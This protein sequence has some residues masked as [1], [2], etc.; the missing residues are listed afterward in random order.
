MAPELPRILCP[1]HSQGAYSFHVYVHPWCSLLT[2]KK[3]VLAPRLLHSP[4]EKSLSLQHH[5]WRW[6]LTRWTFKQWSST[7]RVRNIWVNFFKLPD[8]SWWEPKVWTFTMP[9]GDSYAYHTL[10]HNPVGPRQMPDDWPQ[11]PT[12]SWKHLQN[13]CLRTVAAARLGLR[14]DFMYALTVLLMIS[15]L[16]C[17][18][19]WWVRGTETVLALSILQSSPII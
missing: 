1:L 13:R 17:G 6:G 9:P 18:W 19:V 4:L 11:P 10:A 3:T 12:D 14:G 2:L 7:S 15:F 8:W 5:L 16:C